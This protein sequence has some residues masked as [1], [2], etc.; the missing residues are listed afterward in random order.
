M[1]PNNVIRPIK[2]EDITTVIDIYNHYIENSIA[3]FETENVS[4]KEMLARIIKV[5]QDNF[6]WVVITDEFEEVIGYAYAS[7]WRERFAYSF[8]VEITVYISKNH[9]GKGLGTKLYSYLFSELK[10]LGIHSVI[11]GITLP[12]AESIKLH[13]KF[14]MTQVANFKEVGF[15]FNRWLDVGYWQ[16]FISP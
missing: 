14:G 16:G 1:L 11:S 5:Q 10:H 3:T 8:S 12:N 15:K 4:Y 7:K 9:A 13:E 6:P 2:T